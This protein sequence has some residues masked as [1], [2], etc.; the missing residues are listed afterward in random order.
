MSSLFEFSGE[1]AEP[2]A[3]YE[4]VRCKRALS[5]SALPDMDYALNPYSGCE[6]GC[7]YCYAPEVT[8]S[9]WSTWR[10][11]RVKTNI[12]ERMSKEL[13]YVEG[14]IGIGTVTDPYQSVEKKFELTKACL[15]KL[16]KEDRRIH[17]HTKSD[18]ILR[19]IDLL[20]RMK[21]VIALT[22][23]GI[24]DRYSKMT[25]PGAPL[26]SRRLEAL[27]V[28]TDEGLDTYA[29]IGPVL[30]HLNGKEDEF[31][32][33]VAGT[34]VKKVYIDKL[35][36]RPLLSARLARMNITDGGATVIEKIKEN[37]SAKGIDVHDVFEGQTF[38]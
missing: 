16:Q 37:L 7:V 31:S 17:L 18:L 29:L 33:A 25:E 21:G 34:G 15:E 11:V 24:D 6:H 9:E 10:V 36:G 22:I 26:P 28:L 3:R 23:T 38:V 2:M 20:K 14:V 5:P 13:P 8:H 19:D 35:N 4:L 12:V 27:R 32:N 1:D 30:S